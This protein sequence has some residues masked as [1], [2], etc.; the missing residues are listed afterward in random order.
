MK[1]HATLIAALP[2]WLGCGGS[3]AMTGAGGDGLAPAVDP[4]VGAV[5][6]A[7]PMARD[8]DFCAGQRPERLRLPRQMEDDHEELW[9]EE[10]E[11]AE[12]HLNDAARSKCTLN[13][14]EV[15]GLRRYGFLFDTRIDD[16]NGERLRVL[17]RLLRDD[18]DA[19][20][21]SDEGRE[22]L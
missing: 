14:D 13:A 10:L 18:F 5:P 8:R 11:E 15:R 12:D 20:R 19:I 6:A 2:L 17:R 3:P 21:L 9:E 4:A 1:I 22:A 16:G 7:E